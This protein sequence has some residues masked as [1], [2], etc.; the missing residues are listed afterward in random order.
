LTCHPR[1]TAAAFA[2]EFSIPWPCGYGASR[3]ILARFGTASGEPAE[4]PLGFGE[5]LPTLYVIGPDGNARWNDGRSRYRHR[6]SDELLKELGREIHK[7][8]AESPA[9]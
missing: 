3:Q 8:L 6:A 2:K 9:E 1:Q 5:P 4:A 7:A